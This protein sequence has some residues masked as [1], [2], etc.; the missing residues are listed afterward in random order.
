VSK[1]L[2][3]PSVVL[4]DGMFLSQPGSPTPRSLKIDVM[5]VTRT[6]QQLHFYSP[7]IALLLFSRGSLLNFAKQNIS[8]KM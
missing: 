7:Q 1:K 3:N 2:G 5:E 8:N 4:P 6:P